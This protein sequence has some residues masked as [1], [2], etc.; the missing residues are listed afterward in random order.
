MSWRLWAHRTLSRSDPEPFAPVNPWESGRLLSVKVFFLSHPFIIS[1]NLLI[2]HRSS[3][4]FHA[5]ITF[6]Q[7]TRDL[8]EW[9]VFSLS[10][11]S[12]LLTNRARMILVLRFWFAPS[13][14]SHIFTF[15]FPLP[16]KSSSFLFKK[17]KKEWLRNIFCPSDIKRQKWL[18]SIS[19]AFCVVGKLWTFFAVQHVQEPKKK[20]GKCCLFG[21]GCVWGNFCE[22]P[23]DRE[24]GRLGASSSWFLFLIYVFVIFLL[25]FLVYQP[26]QKQKP[27]GRMA[28]HPLMFLI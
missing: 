11:G 9:K 2:T 25:F 15:L 21:R 17:N 3:L 4:W 24:H 23:E 10:L 20:K 22:I 16:E 18:W 8:S 13:E 14:V 7:S 27:K 12:Q 1:P 5:Y 19:E 6:R 26:E 28:G